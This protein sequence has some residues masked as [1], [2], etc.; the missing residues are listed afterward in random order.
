LFPYVQIRNGLF[1]V[2]ISSFQFSSRQKT[3]FSFEIIFFS[4]FSLG[5]PMNTKI[6]DLKNQLK[7]IGIEHVD[8]MFEILQNKYDY[9]IDALMYLLRPL[10]I[11]H[12]QN[13]MYKGTKTTLMSLPPKVRV[14]IDLFYGCLV[15]A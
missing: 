3:K 4:F 8:S 15:Y 12:S 9:D 2:S 14:T 11:R 13:Q 1:P 10:I 5:T 7:F 6:N